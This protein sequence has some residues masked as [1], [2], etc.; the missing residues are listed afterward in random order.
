M[1]LE[2]LGTE[3]ARLRADKNISQRQLAELSSIHYSNIAKLEKGQYN[4]SYTKLMQVLS[5]LG[6]EL[7]VIAKFQ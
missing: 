4:I 3:I 2:D 7:I 1:N 5:A 6:C